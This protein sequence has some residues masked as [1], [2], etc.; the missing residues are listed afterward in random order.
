MVSDCLTRLERAFPA[1]DYAGLPAPNFDIEDTE[2]WPG[3]TEGAC[4]DLYRAVLHPY[5]EKDEEFI[6]L[7]GLWKRTRAQLLELQEACEDIEARRVEGRPAELANAIKDDLFPLDRCLRAFSNEAASRW[8]SWELVHREQ[9]QRK[10]FIERTDGLFMRD[11]VPLPDAWGWQ[12]WATNKE[13]AMVA[14][15]AGDFPPLE[16][17]KDIPSNIITR[18]TRIMAAERRRLWLRKT[19]GRFAGPDKPADSEGQEP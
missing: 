13:L 11:P 1:K 14:I 3:W 2:I 6:R 10:A 16:V 19:N 9:P 15:A 5:P 7:Y 4:R 17:G 8:A 18:M 12:R